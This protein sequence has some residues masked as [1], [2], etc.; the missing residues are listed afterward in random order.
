MRKG[1]SGAS[2]RSQEDASEET[3][4]AN[5]PSDGGEKPRPGTL[6][7]SGAAEQ[8]RLFEHAVSLLQAQRYA[9]AQRWF[10]RAAHGPLAD[11]A[12]A[13]LQR[14]RMCAQRMARSEPV[15]AG[16]EDHYNYAIW[17]L[18][19]RRLAEA[20]VHL[21]K[22]L[23]EKPQDSHYYYALALCRCWC[24]DLAGASRY[25]RRAI[26]LDPAQ[27]IAARNDPDFAPFLNQSPLAEVLSPEANEPARRG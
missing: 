12:H 2:R 27:R 9:E 20:E 23:A 11:L 4:R 17:L 26:E 22:A 19:Q 3:S 21:N 14:A 6:E 5:G 16:A 1:S 10:E 15:L 25:M 7:A 13:A 24:G 8:A 18:N